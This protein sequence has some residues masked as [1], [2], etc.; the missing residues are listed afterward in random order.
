[1]VKFTFHSPLII[2][3]PKLYKGTPN[4][5]T[6]QPANAIS[7]LTNERNRTQKNPINVQYI[8]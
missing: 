5:V 6:F 7:H 1:M 3:V 2:K 4:Q 8:I